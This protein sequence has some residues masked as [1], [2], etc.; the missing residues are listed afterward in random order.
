MISSVSRSLLRSSR[1]QLRNYTNW[2]FLGEDHLMIAQTCRQFADLELSPIAGEL[3][4]LHKYPADKV[5]KLGEMGLMGIAIEGK[6]GGSDLDYLAY[7]IAMQEISRGCASTGVIMSVNNSLYC[8]PVNKYAN[9]EQKHQFLTPCASGKKLGCFMLSEPGNGSDAG[10]ASTT[11][12]DAGDHWIL[13][14]SKAWITNAH[15][16]DFGVVFAT[17]DK[18]LKNKGI[19]A[20]I[21][22]MKN[23]KG[24]SV[25]IVFY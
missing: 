6:F 14:G 1:N 16:A 21:V 5:V 8:G 13:N 19:S 15:D 25:S 11:A 4:K 20:F 7:S 18:S 23:T 17:T 9:E 3:D 12:T 10:A 22:D 24:L 2:T